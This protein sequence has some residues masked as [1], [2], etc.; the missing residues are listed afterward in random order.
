M[1]TVHTVPTKVVKFNA[2]PLF[3]PSNASEFFS[4]ETVAQWNTMMP[5]KPPPSSKFK[6]RRGRV[7]ETN[8]PE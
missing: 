1:L 4:N 3:V 6:P 5:S 7:A 8:G 2:D